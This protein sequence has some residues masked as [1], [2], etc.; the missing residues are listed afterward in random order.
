MLDVPTICNTVRHRYIILT[1][2]YSYLAA[3]L[4]P[5]PL[6]E[7]HEDPVIYNTR[8]PSGETACASCGS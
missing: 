4:R 2:L 1:A 3:I 5:A 6:V 7:S 8:H